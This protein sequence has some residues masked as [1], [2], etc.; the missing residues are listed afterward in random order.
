M[1]TKVCFPIFYIQKS[2]VQEAENVYFS[3]KTG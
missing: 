3:D 1:I 2:I